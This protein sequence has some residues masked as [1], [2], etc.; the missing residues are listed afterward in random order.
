MYEVAI[1]LLQLP[2]HRIVLQRRDDDAPSSAG[3]L[4]FFGGHIENGESPADAIRRELKEETS[5]NVP[6]LDFE[7]QESFGAVVDTANGQETR[8]YY[9][10]EVSIEDDTF[11]VY[12]GVRS[13][14]YKV[15]EALGRDD[16]T[17]SA[18]RVLKQL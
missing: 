4:G 9:L 10:Y 17:R 3:K 14:T 12:E 11:K 15:H 5:L 8:N 16:L 2:D 7:Y 18:E 1:A 6:A 13:E